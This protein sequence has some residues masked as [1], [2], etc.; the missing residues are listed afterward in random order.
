MSKT[1]YVDIPSTMQV[2][3]SIYINPSLLDNNKYTFVEEDFTEEF[4]RI[5]FGSIYNLHITGVENITIDTID[6]YLSSREKKYAIFKVN[7]GREYL[8]KLKDTTRITGFDYYYNRMKK[9]TLLRMYNEVAGMDLSYLYDKDNILD[10]KKKQKQ[11][12]W[13]DNHSLNQI[14]AEIDKVINKVKYKYVGNSDEAFVHAGADID[15]LIDQLMEYPEIGVPLYGPIINNITKG[16]RLGKLYLRSAATGVGKTRSMIADCCNIGCDKLYSNKHQK[17]MKNGVK[18]P[19]VFVT[20]EQQI[21]EIQT[22]MLAFLSGVEQ[23]HIIDNQYLPGELERVRE[24]AALLNSSPIYIKRLPDFSL[25]DI[26][27]TIKFGIS[28]YKAKYFFQDYIHSSMKILSEVSSKSR[29]D[30]LKEYNILFM[31]AVRLKDLCVEH[32]IFIETATQLNAEYR[33]SSI[34]DQNL[35]RGAKS[36]ADK[37]DFGSIMLYVTLEDRES[38]STLL[39]NNGLEPP[40]VKISVYKNRRGKYKDILLWCRANKG[41]CRIE[42]IFV[43]DYLYNIIDIPDLRIKV[44]EKKE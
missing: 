20:T 12:D 18:E 27:N 11:E 29:V 5:L 13:L 36:I 43:T 1:R 30:G 10:V 33:T 37:I 17:W 35:L 22:M 9:M 31:I 38:L 16:A 44:V 3:G 39:Q 14:A 23:D 24:A 6:D 26:E 2:I 25:E 41:I 8:T 40:E 15:D 21:D 7:N 42:P 28:E 32:D 4:H 34:Y 19:C